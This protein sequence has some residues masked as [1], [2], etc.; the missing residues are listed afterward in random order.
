MNSIHIRRVGIMATHAQWKFLLLSR[1]APLLVATYALASLFI[2]GMSSEIQRAWSTGIVSPAWPSVCA[3]LGAAWGWLVWLDEGPSNRMYH[4]SLPVDV[5]LNDFARVLAGWLWLI[6][7]VV[8]FEAGFL[9]AVVLGGA[10]PQEHVANVSLW[11]WVSLLTAAS[12]GYL[13]FAALA[14]ALDHAIETVVLIALLVSVSQT[15]LLS[16]RNRWALIAAELL[17]LSVHGKYGF[18]AAITGM[19]FPSQLE[20]PKSAQVM[21]S[22]W[23]AAVITWMICIAVVLCA[24]AYYNRWRMRRR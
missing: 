3:I 13:S 20:D 14:T 12:L 19:A 10:F 5:T 22:S 7:A 9:L 21:M 4:W 11:Y 1:R 15:L 17:Q 8:V 2:V 24:G 6:I 23:A 16:S 18:S